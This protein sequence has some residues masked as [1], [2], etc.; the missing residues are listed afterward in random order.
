[1]TIIKCQTL[2]QPV[3][4]NLAQQGVFTPFMIQFSPSFC[5]SC[6]CFI[7]KIA[8]QVDE[9]EK[10][11]FEMKR[12]KNTTISFGPLAFALTDLTSVQI[13]DEPSQFTEGERPRPQ[14]SSPV[15]EFPEPEKYTDSDKEVQKS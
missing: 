15:E 12:K 11:V 5:C 13:C 6:L 8:F 2:K 1:M 3:S 9:E 10:V 14:G 4:A 7:I